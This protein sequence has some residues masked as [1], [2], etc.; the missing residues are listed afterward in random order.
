MGGSALQLFFGTDDYMVSTSARA[1]LDTWLPAADRTLKLESVDGSVD[2]VSA[3]TA[4]LDSCVS[5]LRTLG[6]FSAEKVVWLRDVA[7]LGES[8]AGRSENVKAK[9]RA[10]C[11]IAA[12]GLPDGVRLLVTARKIHKL[13]PFYKTCQKH[14]EVHEHSIPDRPRD[15][16]KYAREALHRLAR[17]LNAKLA[18][19]A[20]DVLVARVGTQTGILASELEKLYLYVGGKRAI[21]S[22]DVRAV[23]AASGE[24]DAWELA[25]A[26]GNRNLSTC[27]GLSR[28]LLFQKASAQGLLRILEMKIRELAVFRAAQDRRWYARKGRGGGEWAALPEAVEGLFGQAFKRDPRSLHPYRASLVAEQAVKFPPRELRRCQERVLAAHESLVSSSI[29]DGVVMELTLIECLS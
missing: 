3:A 18:G 14:G 25:D 26:F 15:A 4:S 10:L 12:A 28:R 20:G 8:P 7:F 22:A 27:L 5:A 23:S 1:L 9:V 21:T 11:D 6:F 19:D 2:S 17:D 24:A 16:E 13:N 29:P